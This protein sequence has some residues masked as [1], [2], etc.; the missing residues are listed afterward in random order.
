MPLP[1]LIAGLVLYTVAAR[2]A[3][4]GLKGG[5]REAIFTLINLAGYYAFFV[6]GRDPA[7]AWALLI[8]IPIILILYV[9]MRFF[10]NAKD[11][12]FWIAFSAPILALI[13][14]RYAP[15]SLFLRVIPALHPAVFVQSF[16]V[17]PFFLGISYL[18]F[19]CSRLVL[20][21]RNGQVEKPGFWE[22]IGFCV[23]VPT[24]SVGPINTYRNYRQGFAPD[25]PPMPIDRALLRILVGCVKYLFLGTIFN[26]LSYSGLLLDDH[27]HHW[28]E[29]PIAAVFYYFY[30]YCNF[31]GFC[32]AAIGVAGLIGIPVPENFHEPFEARNVKDFWNRWHLTLSHYMRDIV[33]SPLSKFLA[34]AMGPSNVDQAIALAIIVVFLLVGIWHGVGGHYAAF[35]LVHGIGVSANHYYTIGL[36]KWL[37]RDRFKAYNA[38]P[39]IRA[40][41][42]VLTFCYVAGSMFFFAN[43]STDMKEIF[44]EMR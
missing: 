18:A 39:L 35:G 9:A 25:P 23:F 24:M 6:Y 34:R 32:D 1:F 13:L 2:C 43:T 20:E 38:N 21:V 8:Y 27:Y 37:G 17:S 28:F 15:S 40:V 30:L 16:I 31:S 14:I 5:W 26:Q 11:G 12:R 44:S 7:F 42:I 3:L 4:V 19:R 36:K 41:A 33:F 22:Y 10:S 29:L